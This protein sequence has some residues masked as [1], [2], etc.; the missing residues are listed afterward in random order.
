MLLK[1]LLVYR[2]LYAGFLLG[3]ARERTGILTGLVLLLAPRTSGHNLTF[4][5][6]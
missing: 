5:A 3:T 4:K 2:T 6:R 1:L